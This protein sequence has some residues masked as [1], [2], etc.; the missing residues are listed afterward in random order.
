MTK[1]TNCK[2]E[3]KLEPTTPVHISVVWRVQFK[4]KAYQAAP[5]YI[6]SYLSFDYIYQGYT[7]IQHTKLKTVA[8]LYL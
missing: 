8:M 1:A 3:W 7:K 2:Y 4:S 6:V 5:G